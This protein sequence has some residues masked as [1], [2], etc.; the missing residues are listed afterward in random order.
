[1][2]RD[3]LVAGER[4]HWLTVVIER[5]ESVVL[6]SGEARLRLEPVSEVSHA[7]RNRPLFYYL[8]DNRRNRPVQLFP[9]ANGSREAGEDLFWQLVAELPNAEGI[10]PEVLGG[11]AGD[12][13]L[14]E[15]WSDSGK[16]VGELLNE[17]IALA[18]CRGCHGSTLVVCKP[19]RANPAR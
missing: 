10:N 1:M 16:S 13:V 4:F 11:G 9:M 19:N 14:V 3:E 8:C 6:L 5:E 15:P 2:H 7:T 18:G 17:G 12:S